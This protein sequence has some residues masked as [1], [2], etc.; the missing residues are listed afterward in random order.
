MKTSTGDR[1]PT[2]KRLHKRTHPQNARYWLLLHQIAEK[3]RP[4]GLSYSPETW[5]TYLKSRF[6]GC[7][8]LALPNGKT[9]TIPHS[10]AVLD[11]AE[12]GEYMEKVEAWAAERDVWLEEFAT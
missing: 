1:C 10:T 8:E 6:L 9:M 2:C 7:D 3:M 5:H 12:F 4:G 11:V